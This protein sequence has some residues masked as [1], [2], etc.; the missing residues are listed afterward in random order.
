MRFLFII[1]A[2]LWLTNATFAQQTT[3]STNAM[4]D[5]MQ[6]PAALGNA[7]FKAMLDENSTMMGKLLAPDFS[8]TS[9]D[10]NSVD[11]DLLLQGLGGGYVIVDTATVSNAR[12]RQYNS[13]AAVMTGNWKAKGNIQGQAFDNN[14]AFSVVSTKQN[15]VWKIVNIQFTPLR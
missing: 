14:V 2:T 3:A 15:G 11:G 12:T 6:D 8:I 5:P 4:A 9:F 13:D 10:G 7:F 1:A